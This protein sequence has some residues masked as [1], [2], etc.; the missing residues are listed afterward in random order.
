[1]V[2]ELVLVINIITYISRFMHCLEDVRRVP[3]R[4]YHCPSYN[5]L[6]ASQGHAHRSKNMVINNVLGVHTGND[7]HVAAVQASGSQQRIVSRI[8]VAKYTSIL[9]LYNF[10]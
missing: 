7:R 8:V 4:R 3:R 2:A 9:R 10:Q 1:M 5:L 6:H